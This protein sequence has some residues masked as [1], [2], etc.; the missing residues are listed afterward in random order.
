MKRTLLAFMLSTLVLLCSCGDGGEEMQYARIYFPLASRAGS[1]GVFRAEFDFSRDTT[2][3]IGAYCAGSILPEE[4]VEVEIAPAADS[5]A[6]TASLSGWTLLPDEAWEAD[7]ADMRVTVRRGTE[8][9]DMVVTFHTQRLDPARKYIL[10]L[11]IESV[12][13]YEI[14]PKYHTLFFGVSKK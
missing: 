14:A 8:R 11:R 1:D 3:I 9:G 10:P 2:F 12:S 7:P 13:H 4:D 6:A 5:L